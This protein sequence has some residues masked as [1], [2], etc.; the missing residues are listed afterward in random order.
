MTETDDVNKLFIIWPFSAG[1]KTG[2]VFQYPF[3]RA[4]GHSKS[5]SL[6]RENPG[7]AIETIKDIMPGH[8]KIIMPA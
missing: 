8:Y 2:S 7:R 3:A 5:Y 4:R 6:N 1:E